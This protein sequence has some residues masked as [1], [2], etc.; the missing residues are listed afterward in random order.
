L[1]LYRRRGYA[2]AAVPRFSFFSKDFVLTPAGLRTE[3][4]K[5]RDGLSA[6]MGGMLTLERGND[7]VRVVRRQQF[8][9]PS[10]SRDERVRTQEMGL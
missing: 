5:V 8:G 3:R 7:T 4:A 1:I 10:A 6:C 2:G 9:G